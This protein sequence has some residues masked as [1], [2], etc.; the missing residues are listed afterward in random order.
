MRRNAGRSRGRLERRRGSTLIE[1]MIS[2]ALVLVGMLALFRVIGTSVRGSSTSS[3][4]SQA[5][6]RAITILESFRQSPAL[7]LGCLANTS[8]VASW[9]NCEAICLATLT[10]AKY[11]GCIYTMDRFSILSQPASDMGQVADRNLQKYV[12]DSRTQ[13][14]LAGVNSNVYDIDLYVGWNEDN[15]LANPAQHIVHLRTGVFPVQ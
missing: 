7:A 8:A 9:A 6:T 11:D 4:L 15:T 3:R 5:Q 10:T 1:I 13:V 14:R 2:L 12:L